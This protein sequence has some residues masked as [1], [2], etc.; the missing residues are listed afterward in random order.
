VRFDHRTTDGMTAGGGLIGTAFANGQAAILP[1]PVDH[2]TSNFQLAT[3]YTAPVYHLRFAYEGSL[4]ENAYRAVT[5]DNA[6]DTAASVP[7]GRM[8]LAPDNQFH[9]LSLSG[10]YDISSRS[11][12]NF[13]FAYGRMQQDERLLPY[14]INASIAATEL[15]ADSAQTRIDTWN[16]DAKWL[17]EIGTRDFVDLSFKHDELENL[18][19]QEVW[20]YVTGDTAAAANARSNLPYSFRRQRLAANWLHRLEEGRLNSGIAHQREERAYQEAADLREDSAWVEWVRSLGETGQ[21]TLHAARSDRDGDYEQLTAI[22]PQ[23][24]PLLRKYTMA[25]RIGNRLR[26]RFDRAVDGWDLGV[27]GSVA[28]YDYPDS[29]LGLTSTVERSLSADAAF[30]VTAATSVTAFV[31]TQRYSFVQAGSVAYAAADWRAHGDDNVLSLGFGVHYAP[32]TLWSA[33]CDASYT[34][35]RGEYRIAGSDYPTLEGDLARMAAEVGYRLSARSRLELRGV[36]EQYDERDWATA[37][38]AP[39]DITNVLSLG[40]GEGDYRATA[41]GLTWYRKF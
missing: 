39:D 38:V 30:R 23:E 8:A 18:T 36:I 13:R 27:E 41:I 11:R 7:L 9:Q 6:F 28:D 35:S 22:T 29:D 25:T 3:N 2:R 21:L 20:A 15:P 12:A 33:S 24:N 1:L 10:G 26:A 16:A 31:G 32:H 5:W 4:F 19:P 34:R 17:Y 37:H 40:E 14:A